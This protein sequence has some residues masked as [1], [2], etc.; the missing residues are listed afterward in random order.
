MSVSLKLTGFREIE[1]ALAQLPAG[2]AKGVARRAMKKELKPIADTANAFWPGSRD[3]VFQITSRI[4]AGQLGDSYAK[5][6]RSVINMFVGSP[7]GANGTP[8]AHLVE[9]GTGPRFQKN[10]RFTGSVAPQPMLQPAWDIHKQSLLEGLGAR[11]WDE[12]EKTIARRAK[13]AAKG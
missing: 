8:H 3:D 4:A 9:F 12:I 6:G 5:R 2:T 10:G 13:R 11:L 1:K 7:G